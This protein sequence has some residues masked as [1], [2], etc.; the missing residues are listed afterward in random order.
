MLIIMVSNFL[1]H[2]Q[3]PLANALFKM[4]CVEY[5]F[6]AVGQITEERK[7]LGYQEYTVDNYP[8]LLLYSADPARARRLIDDADVVILGS[9]PYSFLKTRLNNNKLTFI[10]TERIF[11]NW[12]QTLKLFLRGRW[13]SLYKKTGQYNNAYV[14]CSSAYVHKDFSIIHAFTNKMYKWAYYTELKKFDI[15]NLICNKNNEK[16]QLLWVGRFINWK[17]PEHAVF[18]AKELVNRGYDFEMVFIGIGPQ[19]RKIKNWISSYGL[20]PIAQCSTLCRQTM[21]AFTWKKLTI[22]LFTSDHGEG[23]GAVLN[24]AMNSA[25]CVIANSYA[26]STNFLVK[27]KYN[28]LTYDNKKG[29]LLD[30]VLSVLENRDML[31][32]YQYNA[33]DTILKTWN[34]E[35]AGE[36]FISTC[37]KL[38]E[39]QET[40]FIYVDGPMSRA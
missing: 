3:A 6:I 18:V 27:N 35:I 10:Y 13:Y 30:Q 29:Q 23:W 22:F 14:L 34:A 31:K 26:G 7:H 37:K 28:G 39:R 4:D 8:Y 20:D 32:K 16:V 9:A 38:L 40:E 17:H 33:Y 21:S 19:E 11:K 36:R 12:T 15:K 24:E 25:C 5:Y 1:N 2:H